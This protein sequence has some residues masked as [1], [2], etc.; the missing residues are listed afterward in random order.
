M[1]C[2]FIHLL[3]THTPAGSGAYWCDPLQL[4]EASS[5]ALFADSQA[6]IW[7]LEGRRTRL[8][9]CPSDSEAPPWHYT[10]MTTSSAV[11]CCPPPG[12][13]YLVQASFSEDQFGVVQTTLPSI[14]SSMLV[15][16]EVS[17]RNWP[18]LSQEHCLVQKQRLLV[19][20]I[21]Q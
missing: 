18:Q 17:G 4:P 12:M 15:L 16:Q 14:L 3:S 19:D 13:S 6:H 1:L 9:S 10:C 21:G 7:A 5:Q 8:I 2:L 11:L 20:Y